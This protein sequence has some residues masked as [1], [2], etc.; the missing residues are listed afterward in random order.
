M[1]LPAQMVSLAGHIVDKMLG[2]FDPALLEERYRTVLVSKLS[3]KRSEIPKRGDAA[4]AFPRQCRQRYGNPSAKL[5]CGAAAQHSAKKCAGA[6]D[7]GSSI[8]SIAGY[9]TSPPSNRADHH[10][11]G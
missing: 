10:H 5:G 7:S 9:V 4:G 6:E 1:E 11:H 2:D 8:Q 3:E